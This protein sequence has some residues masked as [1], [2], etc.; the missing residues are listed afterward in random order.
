MGVGAVARRCASLR[1]HEQVV[2][3]SAH[4]RAP[5]GSAR[6]VPVGV[7]EGAEVGGAHAPL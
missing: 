6:G 1:V 5:A 7:P 2:E 4:E 3:P